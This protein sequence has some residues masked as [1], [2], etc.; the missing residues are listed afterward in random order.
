MEAVAKV[1]LDVDWTDE[2]NLLVG[3]IGEV[4]VGLSGI[5]LGDLVDMSHSDEVVENWRLV[6][7]SLMADETNPLSRAKGIRLPHWRKGPWRVVGLDVEAITLSVTLDLSQEDPSPSLTISPD[8]V[9][10]LG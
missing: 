8:Q 3:R 10:P 4:V 5:L 6:K 9:T 1:E 2:G 7:A